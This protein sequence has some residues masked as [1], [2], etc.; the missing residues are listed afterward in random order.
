MKN[1][2][3]FRTKV[4]EKLVR[5]SGYLCLLYDGTQWTQQNADKIIDHTS[6]NT[7]LLSH[8]T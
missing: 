4:V 2:K 5:V 8:R 3:I 1:E 6:L 7:I